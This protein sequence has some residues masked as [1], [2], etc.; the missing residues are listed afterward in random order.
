M[1]PPDFHWSPCLQ[2]G[3]QWSPDSQLGHDH[4]VG[5]DDDH[6]DQ[7]DDADDDVKDQDAQDVNC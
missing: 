4:H 1:P 2:P 6:H 7:D 3:E 5:D